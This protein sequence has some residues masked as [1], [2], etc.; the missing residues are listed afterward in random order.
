[1]QT[2]SSLATSFAFFPLH[3]ISIAVPLAYSC[4]S[5]V[6]L[7]KLSRCLRSFLISLNF[8]VLR[9]EDGR[10]T[11]WQKGHSLMCQNYVNRLTEL[12]LK[13]RVHS[14]LISPTAAAVVAVAVI[15]TIK[16]R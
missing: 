13:W 10:K 4:L 15:V 2:L 6:S 1:M 12:G 5:L 16:A 3:L 8:I 11:G 9:G 7:T 14:I